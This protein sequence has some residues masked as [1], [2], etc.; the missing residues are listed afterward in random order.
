M[1]ISNSKCIFMLWESIYL[2]P[3]CY[4]ITLGL[5]C[6]SAGQNEADNSILFSI[7]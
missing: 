7:E 6:E 4:V 3:E 1:H 2:A 5:I